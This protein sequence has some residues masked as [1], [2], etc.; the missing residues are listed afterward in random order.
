LFN[1]LPHNRKVML[2][3]VSQTT[4]CRAQRRFS[5]LFYDRS[6]YWLVCSVSMLFRFL[7]SCLIYSAWC[8]FLGEFP[9]RFF[10]GFLIFLRIPCSWKTRLQSLT[11]VTRPV[12]KTRCIHAT[13]TVRLREHVK[14]RHCARHKVFAESWTLPAWPTGTQYNVEG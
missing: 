2:S 14:N 5:F 1:H 4:L 8:L 10:L 7:L 12:C 6:F 9:C 11:C 13:L 3:A